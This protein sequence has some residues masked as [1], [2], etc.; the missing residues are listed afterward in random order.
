MTEQPTL[1]QKLAQRA[2]LTIQ[3]DPARSDAEL[4]SD[5]TL[6]IGVFKKPLSIDTSKGKATCLR[7]TQS[8]LLKKAG[9]GWV[10][11]KK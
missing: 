11:A 4:K 6:N 2:I 7:L 1:C 9:V 10:R 8:P 3:L 5:W